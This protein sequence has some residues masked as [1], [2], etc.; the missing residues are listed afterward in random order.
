MHAHIHP[1]PHAHSHSAARPAGM[2]AMAAFLLLAVYF[3]ALTLVSGWTFATEQFSAFWYYIIA[4][5]I[6]FGIQVAL[7]V[8]LRELASVSKDSR[9]VVA[10]SGTTSTAAMVSCCAHYLTN[11]APVLGATGLVAFAAQYQVELFWLGMLC[12]LAGI[13]YVG[14]KVFKATREHEKCLA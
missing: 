7:F 5:S 10:A 9:T 2:G 3:G 13:A 12:N 8:R 4:L 6:G 14:N 1:Q 11:V